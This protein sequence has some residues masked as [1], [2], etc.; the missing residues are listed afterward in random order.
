VRHSEMPARF[1]LSLS[2]DFCLGQ[3][4]LIFVVVNVPSQ[5]KRERAEPDVTRERTKMPTKI[6]TICFV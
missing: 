5:N 4:R 3:F 6:L 2:S 1:S